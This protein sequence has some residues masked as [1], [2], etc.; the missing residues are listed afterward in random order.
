MN[1]AGY[2][3]RKWKRF[4]MAL[5]LYPNTLRRIEAN[6]PGDEQSCLKKCLVKWFERADGVDNR[7]RPTMISLCDAVQR[8]GERAAAD[9]ISKL[10]LY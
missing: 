6:N 10:L 9:Y 7:R 1:K 5:G 2:S 3:G 4:G 8:I